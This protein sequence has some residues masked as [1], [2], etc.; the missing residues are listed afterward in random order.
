[1]NL[2]RYRH[3]GVPVDSYTRETA[4][5][6]VGKLLDQDGPNHIVTLT[7][8]M[9]LAA[10]RDS[11]FLKILD[12]AA[13]V[14]PESTGLYWYSKLFPP[15]LVRGSGGGLAEKT[16]E[17]CTTKRKKVLLFG[18]NSDSREKAVTKLR[19]K[20][21]GLEVDQVPGEYKFSSSN[22]SQWVSDQIDKN[23]PAFAIMGG[24][25][26]EA[27]RW[28][29]RWIVEKGIAANVVGNFGQ[30]I[31]MWAGKKFE[32]PAAI[33]R[34][35]FDWLIRLL[36]E[37]P[38]RRTRYLK[39]IGALGFLIVSDSVESFARKTLRSTARINT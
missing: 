24:N 28:I 18:S 30:M 35:G 26:V 3:K 5:G 19:E 4:P 8:A 36:T 10:R 22:D 32:P 11:N 38:E 1:M 29:S 17:L 13:L 31:D 39:T 2:E 20:Y 37:T 25:E 6:V 23:H 15:I 27:E 12:N 21:P 7:I 14:H 16:I 34:K 33:N 9:Y